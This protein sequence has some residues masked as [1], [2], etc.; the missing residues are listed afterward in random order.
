MPREVIM[1]KGEIYIRP[2]EEK[3]KLKWDVGIK[4]KESVR[5]SSEEHAHIYYR[6]LRIEKRLRGIEYSL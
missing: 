2:V 4:G 3:G 6:L 1:V 5:F